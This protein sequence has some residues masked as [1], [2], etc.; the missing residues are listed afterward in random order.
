[1]YLPQFCLE[2]LT[3]ENST[4]FSNNFWKMVDYELQS[5]TNFGKQ[6]HTNIQDW[7][8]EFQQDTFGQFQQNS[9]IIWTFLAGWICYV[10][11]VC[12]NVKNLMVA[13]SQTFGDIAQFDD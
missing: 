6:L 1:M 9:C 12:T 3:T 7:A 5:V 10:E 13:S 2:M 4:N 11:E 8:R